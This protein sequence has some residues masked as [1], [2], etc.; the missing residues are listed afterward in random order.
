MNLVFVSIPR[1]SI[2]ETVLAQLALHPQGPVLV[3]EGNVLVEVVCGREHLP[4][5]IALGV[6]GDWQAL[7]SQVCRF[8]AKQIIIKPKTCD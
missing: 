2:W 1:L 6:G 8:M 5:L 4:A 3:H 7:R